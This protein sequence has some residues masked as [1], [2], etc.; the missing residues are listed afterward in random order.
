MAVAKLGVSE[1]S[2]AAAPALGLGAE[3][4]NAAVKTALENQGAAFLQ[5][6]QRPP[7]GT[8]AYRVR[9]EI[10]NAQLQDVALPDGGVGQEA[11][12]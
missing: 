10:G 12:V 11:D 5:D 6:D 1:E 4:M 9:A 7:S 2:L 3:Q 8:Q